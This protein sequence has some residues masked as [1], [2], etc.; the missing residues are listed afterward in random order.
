MSLLL[1]STILALEW[2]GTDCRDGWFYAHNLRFEQQHILLQ[3]VGADDGIL[4]KLKWLFPFFTT[5][6]M[7]V[8]RVIFRGVHDHL[9]LL[10]DCGVAS[11]L[12]LATSLQIRHHLHD[13][14]NRSDEY[15]SRSWP[16]VQNIEPLS[17]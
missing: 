6:L 5:R 16:D 7:E 2:D 4:P 9:D 1:F 15:L 8:T 11:A 13:K 3:H 14:L 12:S 10:S 17:M